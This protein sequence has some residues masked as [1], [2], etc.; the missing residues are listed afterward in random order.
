MVTVIIPTYKRANYIE[1]A[2]RSIL[3]QTYQDFEIIVVD[4]NN[5]DTKDRKALEDIMEKYKNNKKI[6]YVKHERNKNG[7]VARNT[8]IEHAKGEYI[9]F[10]DDDDFFLKNRLE[11]MVNELDKNKKYNAAYSISLTMVDKYFCSIKNAVKFGNFEKEILKANSI[12]GTGSNLFFRAKTLKNINGFNENFLRHQDFEVLVRFFEKGNL[13]LNV[14]EL[15]VVKDNSNSINNP[16]IENAIKYR[17]QY[18]KYFE[19]NIRKYKDWKL[20]YYK[21]YIDLLNII[22]KNKNKEKFDTIYNKIIEYTDN[23]LKL[24]LKIIYLK[25]KNKIQKMNVIN[26]LNLIFKNK[27][28]KNK[29]S[30]RIINEIEEIINYKR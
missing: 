2:I 7:A 21:N 19:E 25:I 24:K 8:G 1:R 12:I 16:N 20:I 29:I 6:K 10:L 9:T 14:N 26:K 22:L 11:I 28:I 4:D 15:L 23:K 5:P 13:M 17:E 30:K 18:L 27:K 3:N